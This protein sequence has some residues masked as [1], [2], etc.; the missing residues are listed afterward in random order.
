MRLRVQFGL[1]ISKDIS[2][3]RP[4]E[5]F[6]VLI[7]YLDRNYEWIMYD[8]DLTGVV[9]T[10]LTF[11]EVPSYD[12]NYGTDCPKWNDLFGDDF[13]KCECGAEYSSFSWDHMRYCKL[14]R[15][16]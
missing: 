7:N 5:S 3:Y 14:W 12:A 4:L 13:G 1:T 6:P 10:I 15:R 16:W 11:A 8:K 2:W 9:D